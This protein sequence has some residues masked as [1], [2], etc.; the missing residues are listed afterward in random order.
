MREAEE[1]SGEGLLLLTEN[2]NFTTNRGEF[3]YLRSAKDPRLVLVRNNSREDNHCNR[4]NS[5]RISSLI[6]QQTRTDN[7]FR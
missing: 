7:K 1:I 5:H 2:S 3:K 6:L 4:R